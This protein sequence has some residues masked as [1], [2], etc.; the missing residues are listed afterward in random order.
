[1]KDHLTSGERFYHVLGAPHVTDDWLRTE[2]PHLRHARNS[3]NEAY[4]GVVAP[5]ERRDKRSTERA[6]R[7]GDKY[8]HADS[9]RSPAIGGVLGVT[10]IGL[11]LM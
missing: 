4:D 9:Y 3:A 5:Y 8:S 6:G 2:M 7:S 1:M 10:R 11:S